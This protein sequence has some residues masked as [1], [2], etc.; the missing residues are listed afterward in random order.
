MR[1]LFHLPPLPFA[2]SEMAGLMSEESVQFHYLTQHAAYID[3]TNELLNGDKKKFSDLSI[4]NIIRVADGPLFNNASEVWNH[5]FL[6]LSLASPKSAQHDIRPIRKPIVESF[7]GI[8][9]CKADFLKKGDEHFGS[10]WL[11]LGIK[12][13]SSS[14]LEWIEMYDAESPLRE[15]FLPLLACDLWEH[16]YQIDFQNDRG[17]YLEKF[18]D[19]LNWS[20]AEEVMKNGEVPELDSMLRADSRSQFNERQVGG[21]TF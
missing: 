9:D 2:P 14:E 8:K 10:G 13:D 4:E 18:F 1:E 12:A 16:A 3:K 7:G 5:T 21:I 6:W 11:W 19:H 17:K 20:F 15:G